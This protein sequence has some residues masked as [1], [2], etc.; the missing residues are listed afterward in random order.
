MAS[1]LAL[2]CF[3]NWTMKTHTLGAGKFVGFILTRERNETWNESKWRY[4]HRNRLFALVSPQ[5]VLRRTALRPFSIS[6]ILF[7]LTAFYCFFLEQTI[8]ESQLKQLL[9]HNPDEHMKAYRI[10]EGLQDH[11]MT[12]AICDSLLSQNLHVGQTLFILQFMLTN[13]SSLLSPVRTERLLCTKMGAKAL[14]CLPVSA[15]PNYEH[16]VSRPPLLL[17]QL[18]M[19]MKVE[20][21]AKVFQRIQVRKDY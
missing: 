19:N 4:D 18:L 3:T 11:D 7:T 20:W 2:Q 17:E 9:S 8:N 6:A 14:L 5:Y 13:L 12:L 16:L 21:A 1:A 15:R 10:L